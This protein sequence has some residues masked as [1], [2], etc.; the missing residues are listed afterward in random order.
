MNINI[1]VWLTALWICLVIKTTKPFC[2]LVLPLHWK[3]DPDICSLHSQFMWIRLL[4]KTILPHHY[5]HDI[6]Y[7]GY[8]YSYVVALVLYTEESTITKCMISC[9]SHTSCTYL[10]LIKE[11]FNSNQDLSVNHLNYEIFFFFFPILVILCNF[12]ITINYHT[13]NALNKSVKLLILSMCK[14]VS[15]GSKIK[16]FI[17][18]PLICAIISFGFIIK[19]R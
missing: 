5:P 8:K 16:V 4:Y 11:C 1:R 6:M 15:N 12:F 7:N 18:V 3:Q 2:F 14:L 10:M 19:C 9:Q 13:G 17:V